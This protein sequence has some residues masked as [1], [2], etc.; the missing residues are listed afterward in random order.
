MV[1]YAPVVSM[2][3]LEALDLCTP[4]GFHIN[5]RKKLRLPCPRRT[6]P[7]ETS[8]QFKGDEEIDTNWY[9]CRDLDCQAALGPL[10]VFDLEDV[11]LKEK[12]ARVCPSCGT[13]TDPSGP[14][15]VVLRLHSLAKY[16]RMA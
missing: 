9:R 15:F 11:S 7:L 6:N 8:S 16:R 14:F 1:S 2:S 13:V 5:L 10:D 12:I 3:L 4:H